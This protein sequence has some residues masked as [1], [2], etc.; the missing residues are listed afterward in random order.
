MKTCPQCHQRLGEQVAACPSCGYAFHLSFET[1]DGYR[2]EKLLYDGYASV[3]CKAVHEQSGELFTLRIYKPEARLNQDVVGRLKSEIDR[4]Q[5]LQDDC[6]VSHLSINQ[7]ED[8][9][10]YRVSEWI[11]AENWGN[12][13]TSGRLDHLAVLV[14]IFLQITRIVEKLH[15]LGHL[16]PHLTLDDIMVFN[17]P[18]ERLRVKIDY[19]LS[20]F[21]TPQLARPGA[22]LQKL[23]ATHPDIQKE[24]ALDTRSDI[25]SL[26]KLFVE[27]MCADPDVITYRAKIDELDLPRELANLVHLMLADDPGK[28]PQAITEVAALLE[29]LNLKKRRLRHP[30]QKR[31]TKFAYRLELAGIRQRIS[32]LAAFIIVMAFVGMI[33]VYYLSQKS[34]DSATVLAQFAQRYAPSVAFVISDYQLTDGENTFYHQR[35]EGT[36]FLVDDEG[37]MLTNRHVVCPWL[38]DNQLYMLISQLQHIG[39]S[40]HIKYRVYL[41]FEG[42]K[43]FKRLPGLSE[44]SD[45]EDIYDITTAFSTESEPRLS[46][47]GVGKPPTTTY[48]QI[49]SPLKEDFAVLKIDTV[50]KDLLTLPIDP[51]AGFRKI[52]RL[53]PIIALGFPLG[54]TT[55]ENV[56]NVSVTRGHVRRNFENA[57]QVDTSIYKGNSG[58][59][60]I[61]SHGMVVGIA[62]RVAVDVTEGSEQAA[63]MLSDI[64]MVLPISKA[65][66][67]VEELKSGH[68]KW[69]GV[70]DLEEEEK[71]NALVQLARGRKW[72]DAAKKADEALKGSTSPAVLM[73]A[74]LMHFCSKNFKRARSLF[75]DSL[76]MDDTNGTVRIMLYLIDWIQLGEQNQT[77]GQK[78]KSLDWRSNWELYARLV[79]I[80]EGEVESEIALKG[81]YTDDERGWL[82]YVVGLTHLKEKRLDKAQELMRKAVLLA[83]SEGWLFYITLSQLEQIENLKLKRYRRNKDKR[84]YRKQI[85]AF[86]Q[87]L[88]KKIDLDQVLS[89]QAN[90]SSVITQGSMQLEAKRALH[91]REL[92]KDPANGETIH[93]LAFFAAMEEDWEAAL[94]YTR[95]YLSMPGRENANRLNLMLWEPLILQYMG[96]TSEAR[97][98]LE[99]VVAQVNST[100]FQGIGGCLLGNRSEKDLADRAGENPEYLLT[101]YAALGFWAEANGTQKKALN[102]YREALSTY[103]DEWRL[104]EFA[105]E[106]I[107]KIRKES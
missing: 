28:R 33:A 37:Y 107:K 24:R 54:S 17:E 66:K 39:I 91:E 11:E 82:A 16:I 83:D 44:S 40:V 68:V 10:W 19:K 52:P 80:L 99:A 76:S 23:M 89:T 73:S 61:D 59:P 43:A 53:E 8:G 106:R 62:S 60:I 46:I 58:G 94:M 97:K 47:V 87:E 55:Q 101:A 30:V 84:A 100:W 22:T 104:Y 6:F 51:Q 103:M 69:N 71:I 38:E 9:T 15:R 35:S 77:H 50:P 63:M 74:A 31:Q 65:A 25:W 41:W 45:I 18:S 42:S 79:R 75:Q 36:A 56:V 34:H 88:E 78:L 85:K 32:I 72:R 98:K 70:L 20:R 95:Q 12:L 3:L 81:G 86:A 102:Y 96:K 48:Q 92:S 105:W 7:A 5:Q 2:I 67:F 1:I 93:E 29:R 13:L 57:L 90:Q 49:R 27:L 14:D 64:G 4:L 21:L 26:G